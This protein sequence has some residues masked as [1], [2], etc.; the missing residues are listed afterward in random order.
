MYVGSQIFVTPAFQVVSV[1][2][3]FVVIY[4]VEWAQGFSCYLA[5]VC[6][7]QMTF[8]VLNVQCWFRVIPWAVHH[9]GINPTFCGKG[10]I[11]L[12]LQKLNLGEHFFKFASHNVKVLKV[13]V[14][15]LHLDFA[16]IAIYFK[17]IEVE[18]KVLF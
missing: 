10:V 4:K 11:A 5:K 16:T 12:N 17:T 1:I 2:R 18:G 7:Y 13:T 14:H 6:H 3:N 15:Y 8:F 9:L